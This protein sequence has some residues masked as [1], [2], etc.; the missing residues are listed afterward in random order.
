MKR[1]I[2]SCLIAMFSF[3]FLLFFLSS[4]TAEVHIVAKGETLYSISRLYD[5]SVGELCTQNNMKKDDVLVA[6]KKLLVNQK[7]E[8]LSATKYTVQKGDTYYNI[9]KRYDTDV[10]TLL[11]MNGFEQNRTLKLGEKILVPSVKK[12]TTNVALPN[13]PSAS[14][15]S[16]TKK[17]DASLLWPLPA[18]TVSYIK[19]KISGVVLTSKKESSVTAIKAGTVMYCGPYRGYGQVI[20]VGAKT[21][22][23]YVYIGLESTNVSKGDYVVFKDKLGTASSA[24]G[25]PQMTLMV[26]LNGKPIDPAKAPRG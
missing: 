18:A 3:A 22:H 20:F 12:A 13:I 17:G 24:A 9:S 14:Q 2:F 11:Q 21:G 6:G 16:S 26:F 15:T 7:D 4:T 8:L 25:S 19:T 10:A 1:R 5:I 23:I